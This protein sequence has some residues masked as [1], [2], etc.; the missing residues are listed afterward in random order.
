MRSQTIASDQ[1]AEVAAAAITR[2]ESGEMETGQIIGVEAPI[3]TG[4][5]VA[6]SEGG[7]TTGGVAAATI[8]GLAMIEDF[9]MIEEFVM[10]EVD[11]V[12]GTGIM[13]R[14]E[15]MV[16]TEAGPVMMRTAGA[17]VEAEVADS[18]MRAVAVPSAAFHHQTKCAS[19]DAGA[20]AAAT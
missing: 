2:T 18:M 9:V 11:A 15:I 16:E 10:I 3:I 13:K 5:A 7:G 19:C 4:A 8:G 14:A 6:T 17:V 20:I 1:I 12:T